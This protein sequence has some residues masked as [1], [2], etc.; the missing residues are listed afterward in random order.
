MFFKDLQELNADELSVSTF[1][2]STKS[3]S[4]EQLLNALAPIYVILLKSIRTNDVQLEKALLP[5]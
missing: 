1:E 4:L 2:V 5:I 3:R